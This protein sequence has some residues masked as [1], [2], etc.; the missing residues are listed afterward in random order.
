MQNLKTWIKKRQN[1]WICAVMLWYMILLVIF[2][3][4]DVA[5]AIL[6]CL[7]SPCCLDHYCKL[8]SVCISAKKSTKSSKRLAIKS[9]WIETSNDEL[10]SSCINFHFVGYVLCMLILFSCWLNTSISYLLTIFWG[11][12]L[13]F[14]F[15]KFSFLHRSQ[16]W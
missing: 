15:L 16:I 3:L 9:V 10:A 7:P 2:Q 6:L 8:Y 11:K 12:W 13:N 4:L 14:L 5:D 1:T